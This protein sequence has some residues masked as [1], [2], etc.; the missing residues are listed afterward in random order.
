MIKTFGFISI[1]LESQV[2]KCLDL[3]Y[4]YAVFGEWCSMSVCRAG[5]IT[6][7]GLSKK[8]RGRDKKKCSIKQQVKKISKKGV[9]LSIFAVEHFWNASTKQKAVSTRLKNTN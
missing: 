9:V 4:L 6:D 1:F 5:Y 2:I 8:N 3:G 7:R